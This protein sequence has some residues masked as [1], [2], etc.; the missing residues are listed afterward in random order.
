MWHMCTLCVPTTH[1]PVCRRQNT[2]AWHGE[3]GEAA[4]RDC[5]TVTTVAGLYA[6]LQRGQAVP[7]VNYH[8][9]NLNLGTQTKAES[10]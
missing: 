3:E 5:N 9:P 2:S 7:T 10:W 4:I 6:L 8:P 1:L